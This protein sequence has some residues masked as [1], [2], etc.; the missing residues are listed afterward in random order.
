MKRLG[1]SVV[2]VAGV[3]FPAFGQGVEPLMNLEKSTSTAP[4]QRSATLTW[5]GEGQNLI[6][7]SEGVDAQ[8][9]PFK[10]IVRHIYDGMPHPS[11]GSLILTQPP[12]PGSATP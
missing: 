10:N 4:L 7:T 11:T 5:S 6:D 12:T 1:L 8:D 2:V 9:Q 3:T